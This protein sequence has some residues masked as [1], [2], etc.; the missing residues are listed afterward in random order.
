M[1]TTIPNHTP[2]MQ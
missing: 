2:L 1:M